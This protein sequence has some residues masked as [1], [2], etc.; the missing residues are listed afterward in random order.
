MISSLIWKRQ[1]GIRTTFG[2]DYLSVRKV[3]SFSQELMTE[4]ITTTVSE[5]HWVDLSVN[6]A[7]CILVNTVPEAPCGVNNK[8]TTIQGVQVDSKG[9]CYHRFLSLLLYHGGS[10][11]YFVS[12][13][14]IV[15][16]GQ[17]TSYISD[18]GYNLTWPTKLSVGLLLP[19]K[20]MVVF[21][22]GK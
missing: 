21:Q 13:V 8:S 10:N 1:R 22:N 5:I 17:A 2:L 7:I 12:S 15:V 16:F 3:S 14:G 19:F 6:N 20:V 18:N 4:C 11:F 9:G